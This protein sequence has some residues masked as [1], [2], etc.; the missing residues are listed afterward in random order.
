M[1]VNRSYSF[2]EKLIQSDLFNQEQKRYI[3]KVYDECRQE[4]NA[5]I[6]LTLKCS[7]KGSGRPSKIKNRNCFNEMC[8][9]YEKGYVS[10]KTITKM[11]NL[12]RGC[13]FNNLRKAEIKDEPVKELNKEQIKK[14]EDFYNK[15]AYGYADM[16]AKKLFASAYREDFIQDCLTKLW[17]GTLQYFTDVENIDLNI[18]YKTFCHNICENIFNKY[19]DLIGNEKAHKVSN[20]YRIVEDKNKYMKAEEN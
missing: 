16:Y 13:F 12:S 3:K 2:V 7:A 17:G 11:F 19:I 5:K 20:T 9:Y 15:Y 1:S 18:P 10:F 6:K 14:I 4:Q 8:S